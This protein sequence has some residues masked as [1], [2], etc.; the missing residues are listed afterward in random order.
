MDIV[1]A[2]AH[3]S[4]IGPYFA[5]STDASE[6]DDPSWRPLGDLHADTAALRAKITDY[7]RR[8]GTS[9]TRVAASILFQGLAARLWSPM[10]GAAVAHGL[11][12][13]APATHVHWLPAATGPLPLWTAGTA[14]GWARVDGDAEQAGAVYRAVATE[15]LGPLVAAF[16]EVSKAAPA[17]LWG[18]AASALAATLRTLPPAR[19]D[20]APRAARLITELLALGVLADTGH[21]AEPAPG[22]HFFVRRSCC[23]YYRVPG[24]GLCDDCALLPPH[25][26]SA[27]WERAVQFSRE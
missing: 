4:A 19:P 17:M 6:Q 9:E 7:G 27:Q 21:P 25:E 26:R 1:N 8:L 10:V 12:A 22:V 16:H 5:I 11:V 3:V 14:A 13:V 23:L 2:L 20:L 18:N 24:G 15:L